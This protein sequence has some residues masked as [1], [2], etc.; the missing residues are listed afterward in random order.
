MT[1]QVV[2][3]LQTFIKDVGCL[4]TYLLKGG[5]TGEFNNERAMEMTRAFQVL[6]QFEL[7]ESESDNDNDSDSEQSAISKE[8]NSKGKETDNRLHSIYSN[9]CQC[10]KLII[11]YKTGKVL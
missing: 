7:G 2:A 5:K 11:Q 8:R 9:S 10:E 6:Q 3:M 4:L 1:G